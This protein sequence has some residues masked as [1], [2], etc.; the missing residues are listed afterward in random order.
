M[1]RKKLK[2]SE[3]VQLPMLPNFLRTD[4]G[5]CVPITSV[6]DAGLREL[7]RLWTQALIRRNRNRRKKEQQLCRSASK[8]LVD[9]LDVETP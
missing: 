2:V 5:A 8:R 3:P 9:I 4:S 7:G 6:S 1:T